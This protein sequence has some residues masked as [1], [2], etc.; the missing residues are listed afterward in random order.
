MTEVLLAIGG[1]MGDRAATLR[2]AT[3]RLVAGGVAVAAVSSLYET[4]PWGYAAQPPFLNGAVR[5]D[6]ALAPLALLRLAKQI[7]GD[8]GRAP[9]FRNAPRPVDIDIALYGD[10]VIHDE[11][12]DLYVPHPR[13]P[14]RGFV[15][16]PLA[17][18]APDWM[19][20]ERGRTMREL[21]IALGPTPE[22]TRYLAAIWW[23]D[24]GTR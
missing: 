20:P 5:G 13:L 22:I 10:D 11:A 14:E 8:L 2:E 23:D 17:E 4:P 18:V 24:S 3:R 19:H 6:T 7:E 1:N 16:V 9:S 15:L 12:H 21:R